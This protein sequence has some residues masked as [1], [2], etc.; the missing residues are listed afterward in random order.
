MPLSRRAVGKVQDSA[1]IR[2][3]M[4][5]DGRHAATTSTHAAAMN[6]AQVTRCQLSR[7][8]SGILSS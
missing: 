3:T 5:P 2:V 6:R 8:A 7:I 1:E 4:G